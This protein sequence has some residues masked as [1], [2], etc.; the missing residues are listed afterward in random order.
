MTACEREREAIGALADG[1]LGADERAALETHLAGCA[2]CRA[3]LAAL[4]RLDAV[5]AALAPVTPPP[6]FEA[7]FW[8]RVARGEA[9]PEGVL[10]RLRRWLLPG[11]LALAGAA[12]ALVLYL[13]VGLPAERKAVESVRAEPRVLTAPASEAADTVTGP[14]TVADTDVRILTN[15]RDV[16][17]LQ[18]PDVDA[19]S[20]VDLL[21]DW[22]DAG[23][24]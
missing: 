19:I 3:E 2:G 7:R 24:G 4:E 20:E 16:Q 15:A 1:Q 23:P 6:D 9:A 12:A 11:G 13:N 17:L 22:D 21:E 14:A 18:D 5:F 8:A 10:A